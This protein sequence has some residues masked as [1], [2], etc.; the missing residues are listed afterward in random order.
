MQFQANRIDLLNTVRKVEKAAPSRS[1]LAALKC[2]LL[3]ADA[4]ASEITLYA[5]DFEASIRHV[6]S[7]DSGAVIRTSGSAVINAA[8]LLGMLS[9]LKDDV[10]H[11]GYTKNSAQQITVSSGNASFCINC[12][13]VKDFPR[14]PM[15]V[16]EYTAPLTK[17]C[18]L[19]KKTAFTAATSND[20]PVLQCVSVQHN[21][22]I[23]AATDGYKLIMT[24]LDK[25]ETPPQDELLIPAAHLQLLASISTD[26]DVYN[27]GVADKHIVF[28]KQNMTFTTRRV[29][30][31]FIQVAQLIKA[32]VPKYTAIAEAKQVKEALD[33]VL[34]G[35]D[36]KRAV[37][38]I[39][40]LPDTI[41]IA[42]SS[43]DYYALHEIEA[44]VSAPTP[45]DG[46][47]YKADGMTKLFNVMQGNVKLEIDTRGMLLLKTPSD[48]CLVVA[49]NKPQSKKVVK[50]TKSKNIETTKEAA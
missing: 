20:N 11:I 22:S 33:L 2:I 10:V 47:Y 39:V 26:E 21:N 8:L 40:L 29:D 4:E 19:V 1:T 6:V 16:P 17:L 41:R 48:V 45:T 50:R 5:T 37:V 14:P 43:D 25:Q 28:T 3:E 46:F 42:A 15:P 35:T 12:L 9:L 18:T 24:R 30:G 23:A 27:V 44:T 7:A 13:P 31:D 36:A 32:V 38:N 49:Q 34:A